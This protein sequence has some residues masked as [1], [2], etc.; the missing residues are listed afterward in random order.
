MWDYTTKMYIYPAGVEVH[1]NAPP[2]ANVESDNEAATEEAREDNNIESTPSEDHGATH[3]VRSLIKGA[4]HV[5]IID[6]DNNE[7]SNEHA[8][9]FLKLIQEVEKQ[10]YPR[11]NGESA[12]GG[13]RSRLGLYKDR[14]L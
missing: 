10:L 13:L 6:T 5:E 7:Q 9:T 3:L 14:R 11:H 1:N 12:K 2:P 4:I 8:N